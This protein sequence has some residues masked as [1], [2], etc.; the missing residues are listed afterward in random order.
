MYLVSDVTHVGLRDVDFGWGKA[1]Y[2]GVGVVPGLAS[3]YIPFK[4]AKGEEGLVIPVCLPNQA[5][6]RFVKELDSLLKNNII[7]SSKGGLKSSLII[8]SL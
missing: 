5:M 6:K 3:F 8:S 4:N 7:I 2:G 1:V